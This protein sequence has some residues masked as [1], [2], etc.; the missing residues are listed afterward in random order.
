MVNGRFEA[1]DYPDFRTVT[2]AGVVTRNPQMRYDTVITQLKRPYRY[3]RYV[4]PEKSYGNVAEIE[5]Y[6]GNAKIA[7]KGKILTNSSSQGGN[8]E[9]YVFG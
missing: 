4:S 6:S 2:A 9:E 5:F 1:S 7:H 3:W 8:R